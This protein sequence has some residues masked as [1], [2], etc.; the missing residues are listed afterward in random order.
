VCGSAVVAPAPA[1]RPVTPAAFLRPPSFQEEPSVEGPAMKNIMAVTAQ[2]WRNKEPSGQAFPYDPSHGRPPSQAFP[3]IAQPPPEAGV[4]VPLAE[5]RGPKP[6]AP[7]PPA[8]RK[9]RAALWV[10]LALVF[11]AAAGAGVAYALDLWSLG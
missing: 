10:L 9:S 7:L 3:D 4:A 11:L 6:E 2:P 5:A 1:P 8:P